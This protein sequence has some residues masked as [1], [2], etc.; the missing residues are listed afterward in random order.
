MKKVC[1]LDIHKDT[2]FACIL[3]EN[4]EAI[5][6]EFTTLT[7][8]INSLK[9][10]LLEAGVEEV[11]MESTGIYWI[12]IWRILEGHFNL[13]LVNPYF[14]KQVPGRKSDVKDAQWIATVLQK[15]LIKGSYVP[16]KHIRELREYERRYV[17][18]CGQISRVERQLDNQLTKCNIRITSF[19]SQTG[20]VS[21]MSVVKAIINGE[22]GAEELEKHVHGRVRNKYKEKITEALTGCIT[23]VDVFLLRQSYEQLQMFE[24]QQKELV[25]A[26]DAI[27][28]KYYKEE[29]KLLCTIAGVQELSAMHIIAEIGVDL[30][31]FEKSSHLSSW[32]GLRPR[33]DESAG[34]I[35][36]KRITHGNKYLCRVLVQCAWAVTRKRDC[37][38][39]R[40]YENLCKRKSKKKAL[41]AIARKLLVIIWFILTKHEEYKEYQ[42]KETKKI[43]LKKIQYYQRQIEN[44]KLK[45]V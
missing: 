13:K 17:S 27:C 3:K 42:P 40:K 26:M 30:S 6:E 45:V 25:M 19:A 32:A 18:L 44:L 33:N 38:L 22:R 21:V 10:L 43:I 35:K 7:T 1:G 4:N 37:W 15:D 5:L 41:I 31:S 8:G 24:R 39:R 14:I 28:E 20:S 2:I 34:K 29:M 12:P 16:E 11:A 23:E 9:E 36:S